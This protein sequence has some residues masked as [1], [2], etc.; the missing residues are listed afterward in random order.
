M[1]QNLWLEAIIV[2]SCSRD[3]RKRLRTVG[4]FGKNA[5]KALELAAYTF[6]GRS[7][8]R[9]DHLDLERQRMRREVSGEWEDVEIL[10]SLP[11][12][13]PNWMDH[14]AFG[15]AFLALLYALVVQR[16]ILTS[17]VLGEGYIEG[18]KVIMSYNQVGKEEEGVEKALTGIALG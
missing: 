2:P 16:P 18:G 1:E 12:G 3:G 7:K 4:I 5:A 11:G 10:V 17:V 15:A 9:C 8:V 6:T 13:H 14:Y